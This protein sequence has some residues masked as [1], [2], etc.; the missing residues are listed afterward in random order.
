V[1]ARGFEDEVDLLTN[2]GI[3]LFSARLLCVRLLRLN[4][5]RSG[6]KEEY[7]D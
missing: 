2:S 3:L 4:H 6:A 7:H 1:L 5:L